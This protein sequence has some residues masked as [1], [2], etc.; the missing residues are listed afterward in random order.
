MCGV[1]DHPP[2]PQGGGGFKIGGWVRRFL[3]IPPPPTGADLF[4]YCKKQLAI[5]KTYKIIY[6][7]SV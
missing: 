7:C 6:S 5:E 4:T 2:P 1:S 3:A